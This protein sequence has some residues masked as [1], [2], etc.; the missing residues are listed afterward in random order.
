MPRFFFDLVDDKK[1]YDRKG[2]SL[3]NLQEARK[4]ATKFAREL[5]ETKTEL[6]GE[7]TLAWS[8][9]VCNGKFER[10]LKIPFADIIEQGKNPGE[11]T[12]ISPRKNS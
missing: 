8:V 7:S 6:L 5:M 4:F 1:V 3:P 12:P 9:E 2:I 11:A 10:I